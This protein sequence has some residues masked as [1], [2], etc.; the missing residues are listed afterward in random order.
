[1]VIEKVIV[2]ED[3]D[4]VE[5]FS[6]AVNPSEPD[7]PEGVHDW[8]QENV[9]GNGGGVIVTEC[10]NHCDCT[11]ITNTWA[12]NPSTGEQGLKSIHIRKCVRVQV[13]YFI[14]VIGENSYDN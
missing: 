9:N 2:D 7:C 4:F 13:T 11:K 1:M 14:I 5:S 10:C 8:Y 6:I 12:H 3:Y